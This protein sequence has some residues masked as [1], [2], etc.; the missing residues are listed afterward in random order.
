MPGLAS[1]KHGEHDRT[2]AKEKREGHPQCRVLEYS[3]TTPNVS[4]GHDWFSYF[5]EKYILGFYIHVYINIALLIV[6]APRQ[7]TLDGYFKVF[8]PMHKESVRQAEI[9]VICILQAPH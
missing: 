4:D 5:S 6:W 2:W 8:V 7:E 1:D 3:A 9:I